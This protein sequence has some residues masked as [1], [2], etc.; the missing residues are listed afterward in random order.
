M[1]A[2]GMTYQEIQFQMGWLPVTAIIRL[3]QRS[4]VRKY[5]CHVHV[6]LKI[7]IIL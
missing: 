6:Y 3:I 2:N 7:G 1:E 5:S 4:W